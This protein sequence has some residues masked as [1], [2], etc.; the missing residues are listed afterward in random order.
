MAGLHFASRRTIRLVRP[1]AR[2]A[3]GFMLALLASGCATGGAARIPQPGAVARLEGAARAQPDRLEPVRAL[4]IAYFESNRLADARRTLERAATLGP[5]DGTTVLYLGM[6][7]EAQGDF[8]AARRAYS[9][10]LQFGRTR[11]VRGQLEGRLASLARKELAAA[12]KEAVR[13]EQSLSST[14]GSPRTVAVMPL[15]FAGEDTSLV[16]LG[17]GLAELIVTDLSRSNQL[18]VVERARM[19][20]LVDE[21]AL[22]A[23]GRVDESTSLRAGRILQAGRIV[24]GSIQQLPSEQLRVDAAVVDVSSAMPVGTASGDDRMDALL[25]LQK[26]IV[27]QIFNSLGVQLTVAERNLIEQRPTRSL[28]AFLAFSRGLAAE[29]SG[30]FDMASR[31]FEDA[32]RIDP[33]FG[34]AAMRQ[35]AAAQASA[36]QQVSVTSISAS[37]GNGAEGQVVQSAARGEASTGDNAAQQ[38]AQALNPSSAG[39]VTGGTGGSTDQQA[40]SSDRASESS[41]RSN[42]GTPASSTV[43][44]VIK[45][46]KP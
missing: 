25:T 37:L 5:R 30:R 18:T 12:A 15:A 2:A 36:A 14:P 41:G 11:R 1:L 45:L 23:A 6:A 10:Y 8:A 21:L 4:G 42:A 24:Q 34:A 28:A 29:D 33:G 35:Q 31:F 40:P 20:A 17:R 39:T 38:T 13:T 9:S 32:V 7:A 43:N 19:Q 46:P 44:I 26:E 16:P 27:L 22:T 3:A